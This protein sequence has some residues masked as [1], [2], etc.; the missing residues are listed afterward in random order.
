MISI[1]LLQDKSE[2]NT[3][4]NVDHCKFLAHIF[5]Q[6]G[7]CGKQ[8]MRLDVKKFVIDFGGTLFL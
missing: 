8:I 1:V 5:S 3:I 4:V 7:Y 6:S 2:P